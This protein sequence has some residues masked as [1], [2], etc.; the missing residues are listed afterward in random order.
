VVKYGASS[1]AR[2]KSGLA[3]LTARM[4]TESTEKLGPLELAEAAESLGTTL[5]H[6][7]GRDYSSLGLTV[8]TSD[9]DRAV[10]LLA[11][12]ALR[13]RFAPDELERVRG[14]WI[15]GLVAERQAPERLASMAALRLL[16]GDQHGAPVGGGVSDVKRL[17]REDISS[18]HQSAWR[19]EAAVLV[20]VGDVDPSAVERAAQ[21]TLGGWRAKGAAPPAPV[22]FEA[23]QP[24]QRARVVLVD[25]PGSVQSAIFCAQPFPRRDAPG[26][27][28]R[29]VLSGVVGGLFTSRLNQNLR[30]KN[31]FTYGARSQAIATRDWGAFVVSTSVETNVTGPALAEIF[32]ELGAA[33]DPGK[34]RPIADEETARAKADLVSSLGAHL[35]HVDRV[36][37]D[38]T[39]LFGL[40]LPPDYWSGF[41]ATVA[42]VDT[43]SVQAQAAQGLSPE[44]LIVVVVGDAQAIEPALSKLPVQVERAPEAL[45][46]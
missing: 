46:D 15:D 8:L 3:A 35:E 30:E 18:F 20:V 7:A 6:D 32:A 22:S 44:K 27:E 42:A 1:L 13:P 33:K 5:D 23:Q 41:P 26:H 43:T 9:L 40:R 4:L 38:M 29:Q 28:A 45:I 39:T 19:P 10:E 24:P 25:R 31:A 37:G 14:E 34:G 12:V 17:T 16:L 2:G 36:A 11:E 21:N